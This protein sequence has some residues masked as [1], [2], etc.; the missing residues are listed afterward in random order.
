LIRAATKQRLDSRGLGDEVDQVE[1]SAH[2]RL[3]GIEGALTV[4]PSHTTV[5]TGHVHGG[6]VD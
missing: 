1:C 4:P 2:S 3:I 5:H 6:S